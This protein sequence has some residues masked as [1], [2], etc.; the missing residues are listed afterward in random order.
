M[1]RVAV[2]GAALLLGVLVLGSP[3]EAASARIAALQVGLRAHGFSPG[4]I[5]GVRGPRTTNALVSFQRRKGIRPLGRVGLFE[6]GTRVFVD[7][8]PVDPRTFDLEPLGI[9]RMEVLTGPAAAA[10]DARAQRVVRI[11][12]KK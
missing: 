3:A 12:T 4:P 1:R 6:P 11:T 10:V 8:R 5:D 9:D 7:G 2:V